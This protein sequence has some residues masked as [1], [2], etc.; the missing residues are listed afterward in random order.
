MKRFGATV[1]M[2]F[3]VAVFGCGKKG[4]EAPMPADA[5]LVNWQRVGEIR[6]YDPDNLWEYINGAADRFVS[7]GL[8]RVWTAS[9]RYHGKFEA[10]VDIF[11]MKSRNAA[12]KIFA[13]EH[14]DETLRV[15][16]G[17]NSILA[18]GS[19]VFIKGKYFVR[20][21]AFEESEEINNA[22]F[23]LGKAIE[24]KIERSP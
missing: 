11:E 14:P 16:I 4:K 18:G 12:E 8:E 3:L 21:V 24:R 1:I 17:D 9:Y 19:L 15:D 7:A 22:L 23:I 5:D 10:V 13:D 6:T 2:L 20:V